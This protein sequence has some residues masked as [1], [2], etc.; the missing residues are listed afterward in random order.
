MRQP[1][2]SV[3]AALV[4]RLPLVFAAKGIATEEDVADWLRMRSI[5]SGRE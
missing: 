3:L 1:Y 5:C 2:G 4:E